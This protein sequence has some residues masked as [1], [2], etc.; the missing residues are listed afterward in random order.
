MKVAHFLKTYYH[1]E[2]HNTACNRN[3]TDR[4]SQDRHVGTADDN[5]F[6]LV[7]WGKSKSALLFFT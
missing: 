2:L 6:K 7:R 1:T 5:D 3:S 4:T